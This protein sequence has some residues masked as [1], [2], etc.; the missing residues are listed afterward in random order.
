MVLLKGD[1]Q[2]SQSFQGKYPSSKETSKWNCFF[3]AFKP[4]VRITNAV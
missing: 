1:K 3:L 4:S 2:Y